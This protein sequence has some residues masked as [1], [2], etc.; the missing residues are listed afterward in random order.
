MIRATLRMR[1]RAGRGPE[2]ERAW[3]AVAAVASR[4][5]GN[6][7]QTLL[8]GEPGEYVITS[9]WETRAAFTAF[10][11]SEEQDAVTAP[12]RALRE[13]AR[14]DIADV[15]VHLDAGTPGWAAAPATGPGDSSG[16]R[17]T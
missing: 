16:G 12:L 10:E 17:T 11:R 6:L 4:A 9:D 8:R 5:P 14:M 2:F 15:L 7:R 3:L 13:S 1:V